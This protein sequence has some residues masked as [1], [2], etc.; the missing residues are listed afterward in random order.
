MALMSKPSVCVVLCAG[1]FDLPLSGSDVSLEPSST[2]CA[3]GSPV[4]NE[5]LPYQV[6]QLGQ[7]A[8]SAADEEEEEAL[9]V[10][11]SPWEG[12]CF[13]NQMVP[14]ERTNISS[15]APSLALSARSPPTS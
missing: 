12:A 10:T 8:L 5:A 13:S 6:S 2:V 4:W 3:A 11:P 15:L 1:L 14:L 9:F 7:E